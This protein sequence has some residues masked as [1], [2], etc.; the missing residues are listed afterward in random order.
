MIHPLYIKERIEIYQTDICIAQI[1][2][3]KKLSPEAANSEGYDF[4]G[5]V[6]L[7]DDVL[8]A[9]LCTTAQVRLNPHHSLPVKNVYRRKP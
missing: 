2:D 6:Y 3:E 1:K 4:Q 8:L 5:V 7:S 9:R